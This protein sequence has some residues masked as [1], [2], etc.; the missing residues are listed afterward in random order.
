MVT[1]VFNP[2]QQKRKT[3]ETEEQGMA[4]KVEGAVASA[5]GPPGSLAL[6]RPAWQPPAVAEVGRQHLGFVGTCVSLTRR[7][8]GKCWESAWFISAPVPVPTPSQGQS[9][10]RSHVD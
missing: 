1:L 6:P 2:G 7:G 10:C 4:S 3:G 9:K 8:F 5:S